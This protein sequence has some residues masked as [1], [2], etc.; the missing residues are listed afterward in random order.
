MGLVSACNPLLRYHRCAQFAIGVNDW[1]RFKPRCSEKDMV[2]LIISGSFPP[3]GFFA[4]YSSLDTLCIEDNNSLRTLPAGFLT[5]L[6]A[7]TNLRLSS[8]VLDSL[9][10]GLLSNLTNLKIIDVSDN[11]LTTV[12]RDLFRSTTNLQSIKM[13]GNVIKSLPSGLLSGLS[14]LQELDIDRN[15]LSVL[16]TDFFTSLPRLTSLSMGCPPECTLKCLRDGEKLPADCI[17]VSEQ[18]STR[19][20]HPDGTLS[21][22]RTP[23][24]Q[25]PTS[26]PTTFEPTRAPAT[27]TPTSAPVTRTPSITGSTLQPTIAPLI[28]GEVFLPPNASSLVVALKD[29]TVN[30]PRSLFS[31]FNNTRLAVYQDS[32][33]SFDPPQTGRRVGDVVISV[34]ITDKDT[35]ASVSALPAP[36][37]FTLPRSGSECSPTCG[38][39][40]FGSRTWDSGGCTASVLNVSTLLCT[41]THLTD[42]AMLFEGVVCD[43]APRSWLFVLVACYV[44]ILLYSLGILA[45]QGYLRMGCGI[46]CI[47]HLLIC[48]VAVF[49][50]LSLLRYLHVFGAND[51]GKAILTAGPY[52]FQDLVLSILIESWRQAVVNT[53]G[54]IRVGWCLIAFNVVFFILVVILTVGLTSWGSAS[55]W[56]L[57]GTLVL[58]LL[59]VGF[60]VAFGVGG[61]LMKQ[62]LTKSGVKGVTQV[63]TTQ[64][65]VRFQ[66]V[67]TALC[68]LFAV[69]LVASVCA[70]VWVGQEAVLLALTTLYLAADV[71]VWAVVLFGYMEAVRKQERPQSRSDKSR[72]INLASKRERDKQLAQR[73]KNAAKIPVSPSEDTQSLME[74]HRAPI[75]DRKDT[76]SVNITSEMSPVRMIV[77]GEELTSGLAPLASDV[78]SGS[79][80]FEPFASPLASELRPSPISPLLTSEATSPRSSTRV[81]PSLLTPAASPSRV[82]LPPSRPAVVSSSVKK[83]IRSWPPSPA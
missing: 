16:P 53:T 56:A 46:V 72:E 63:S 25:T 22:T 14:R 12:P 1:S 74:M 49:R 61:Q 80:E 38:W 8:N 6:T 66:R 78:G 18:L 24:T 34:T 57:G 19:F 39:F 83:Q 42:F 13:D 75:E 70:L 23:T 77:A 4:S 59:L 50:I 71:A 30:L 54:H 52:L 43:P 62:H 60:M 55:N 40:H 82:L 44:V 32:P 81:L 7:L 76:Q 45:R 48:G 79:L 21:P 27:Q 28:K 10:S 41:C 9:P 5:G 37:T 2:Q 68:F 17:K 29:A 51:V 15:R 26:A 47:Q 65:G 20:Y 69:E 35:G 36:F 11:R 67:G 3:A 73:R 33:L 58:G 64:M 31:V